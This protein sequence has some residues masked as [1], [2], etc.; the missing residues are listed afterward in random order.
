MA[1]VSTDTSCPAMRPVPSLG[2]R[3]PH[4]MRMTVD[5]PEPFGPRNPKM[6]R[7]WTEKLTWSTAVKLPNLLVRLSHWIM[8]SWGM[9]Q[10][11]WERRDIGKR[12]VDRHPRAQLTRVAREAN[13]DAEHLADT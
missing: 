4:N 6:D 11:L 2:S 12:D 1:F 3:M 8:T 13:F 5:F 10:S 7:F 9:G